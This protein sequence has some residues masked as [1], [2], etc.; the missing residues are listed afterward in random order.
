MLHNSRDL[1]PVKSNVGLPIC[2]EQK[3]KV[4]IGGHCGIFSA[5]VS[6]VRGYKFENRKIAVCFLWLS[7]P[8]DYRITNE[9]LLAEIT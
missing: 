3:G 7:L 9:A 1:A 4:K 6:T 2:D 8:G 5:R